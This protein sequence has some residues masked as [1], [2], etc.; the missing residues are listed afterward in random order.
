MGATETETDD[1]PS[2]LRATAAAD[3]S[4]GGGSPVEAVRTLKFELDGGSLGGG[5]ERNRTRLF[6]WVLATPAFSARRPFAQGRNGK[7]WRLKKTAV[8]KVE[9]GEKAGRLLA[10]VFSSPALVRQRGHEPMTKTYR[11]DTVY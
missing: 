2:L 8:N 11:Q 1:G 5:K 7:P 4:S 9:R 3:P 10:G 6:C